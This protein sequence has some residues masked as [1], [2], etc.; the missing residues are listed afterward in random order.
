LWTPDLASL[1]LRVVVLAAISGFL[2]LGRHWGVP[3]V[4]ATSA[5]LAVALH[6]AQLGAGIKY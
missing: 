5:A 6:F 1:D 4:L 2:L 3:S